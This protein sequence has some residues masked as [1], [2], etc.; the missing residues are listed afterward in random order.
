M[1]PPISGAPSNG[2]LRGLGASMGGAHGGHLVQTRGNGGIHGQ[3]G[4]PG[5][6]LNGSYSIVYYNS[7]PVRSHC[8]VDQRAREGFHILNKVLRQ[9]AACRLQDPQM[10]SVSETP[11]IMVSHGKGVERC[12]HQLLLTI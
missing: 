9:T 10:G 4:A 3:G 8:S 2:F 5:R 6:D 12:Q 1:M 11:P 7:L